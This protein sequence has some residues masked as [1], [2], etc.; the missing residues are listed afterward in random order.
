MDDEAGINIQNQESP[1]KQSVNDSI[2]H[3]NDSNNKSEKSS[4]VM[5]APEGPKEASPEIRTANV[6]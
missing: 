4:G 5:G 1:E 2:L 3:G 6:D